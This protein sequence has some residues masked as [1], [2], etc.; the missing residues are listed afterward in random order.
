M[1]KVTG[2]T[3]GQ[4]GLISIQ[5]RDGSGLETVLWTPMKALIKV[6]LEWSSLGDHGP[7]WPTVGSVLPRASVMAG[8]WGPKGRPAWQRVTAA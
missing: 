7:C 6:R 2:L 5:R 8:G 1:S 3:L 4:I